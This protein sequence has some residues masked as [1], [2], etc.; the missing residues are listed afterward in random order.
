MVTDNIFAIWWDPKFDHAYD[1]RPLLEKLISV[2]NDCLENLKM[3][4]PPN[5]GQD[6]FYNVYIHHNEPG[7]Q[8][9]FPNGW[10]LGQ[11]TDQYRLPF[12]TVPHGSLDSQSIYHE[13]FH[14]FQYSSNSPGF[15]YSA[16]TQWYTESS[17][18]WYMA[19]YFPKDRMT[20]AQAG[21][22]IGNPQLALWHSFGNE[23]PDDPNAN[24]GRP[25]W[26][27]GV[28]QYGMHMLLM[29]LTEVKGIDRVGNRLAQQ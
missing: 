29:F 9:I 3:S 12:L 15:A 28:R 23:A 27:Y 25:G 7:E 19:N 17:A 21:A 16:D 22:I 20:Y 18:Q 11:G 13:G 6:I 14:I 2:R 5:P 4:D 1:T 10:A 24:D 8:D 26:M